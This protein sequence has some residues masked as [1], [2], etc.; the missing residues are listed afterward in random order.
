MLE[1]RHI[2][3]QVLGDGTGAVTHLGERDCSVQRR[4]QKVIEVAPAPSLAPELREGIVAAAV[5][6]AASLRYDNVGTFEFLVGGGRFV[7]IEANPRI[8]VEH[9]VTEEIAGCDLVAAQLR[10]SVG[11]PLAALALESPA[12]A[13]HTSVWAI[14]LRVTTESVQPDGTTLPAAGTMSVYEMPS[15][16][17]I[18]VD[19]S[20]Y[21][22]YRVNTWPRT[23]RPARR[24]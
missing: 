23:M 11:A 5:G 19:G 2:E 16:P 15:G 22:G 6:L 18:R 14:Q 21:A 17:G 12:G 24:R 1:C 9:T 10:L 4:H 3:V 13:E 8:Q 20:G 7:F